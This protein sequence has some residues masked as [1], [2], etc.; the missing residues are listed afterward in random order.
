MFIGRVRLQRVRRLLPVLFGLASLAMA[1][2]GRTPS[3][4]AV[5]AALVSRFPQFVQWPDAVWDKRETIELCVVRPAVLTEALQDLV[6]DERVDQRPLHVRPILAN[7][8][9]R[10]CHVLYVTA[11]TPGTADLLKRVATRPILTVS[12]APDFLDAGGI[13]LLHTAGTRV[14]F[15]IDAA[16]ADRAGL[17]LNFQ[18]LRLATD[19]RGRAK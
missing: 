8:D 3:E 6:A 18:L 11:G 19:V 10:D 16:A 2:E 14:R 7:E 9:P 12:D 5:K 13:V 4:E 17:R 1:Q 15:A